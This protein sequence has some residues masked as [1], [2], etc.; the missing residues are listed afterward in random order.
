MNRTVNNSEVF[1]G[2]NEKQKSCYDLKKVQTPCFVFEEDQFVASLSDM[3]A[4]LRRR[5]PSAFVAY[6]VKTNP[7]PYI[8]HTVYDNGGFAEVT[9]ADEFRL[10]RYTGFPVDRIIYNG[11]MK[12]RET[13]YQAMAGGACVNLENYRELIWL[14]DYTGPKNGGVGV[15]LNI[16]LGEISPEDASPDQEHSRFGFSFSSDDFLRV[17]KEVEN[18]GYLVR[19]IHAHRTSKTRSLQVYERICHYIEHVIHNLNLHL[20]YIDIG[21][22]F[23]GSVPG[24]P[25]YDDYFRV[26]QENLH[27]TAEQTLIVEPGSALIAEPVEF[28][29]TIF[30]IKELNDVVNKIIRSKRI[31]CY[32]GSRKSKKNDSE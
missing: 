5:F 17:V 22:G 27:L 16:N 24:R 2:V 7:L 11:P 30:D 21:G 12:D 20:S 4:A 6:S 28:V 32:K 23:C 9:S 18:C 13:F 15:R 25:G 29:T 14:H 26:M 31:K 8:L 3:Q 1:R 10:A 19:G